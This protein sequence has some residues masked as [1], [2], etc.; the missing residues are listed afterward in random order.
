[1]CMYVY[2]YPPLIFLTLLLSSA[3]F[4]ELLLSSPVE[5][6]APVASVFFSDLGR[7]VASPG[8]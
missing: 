7:I 4:W 5:S 8:A 1:M 6:L 2:V 3:L